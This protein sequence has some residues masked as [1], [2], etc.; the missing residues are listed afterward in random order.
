VEINT[1]QK[2]KNIINIQILYNKKKE[3]LKRTKA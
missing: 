1:T 3:K 2:K